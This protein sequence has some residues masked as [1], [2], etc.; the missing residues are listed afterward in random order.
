MDVDNFCLS[1][2]SLESGT[3]Q[4]QRNERIL[5]ESDDSQEVTAAVNNSAVFDCFSGA[6][7]V[8]SVS[9]SPSSSFSLENASEEPDNASEE[10]SPILEKKESNIPI[11]GKEKIPF[12]R[13]D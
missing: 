2:D 5:E 4:T 12:S 11:T 8:V 6:I 1:D 7:R 3:L 13:R 9:E 10:P